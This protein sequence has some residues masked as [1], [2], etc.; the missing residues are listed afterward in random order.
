[1]D[2][3]TDDVKLLH[4]LLLLCVKIGTLVA[5]SSMLSSGLDFMFHTTKSTVICRLRAPPLIMAPCT[6]SRSPMVCYHKL[7]AKSLLESCE[8]QLFPQI[9][10][11]CKLRGWPLM[12]SV[13][14]LQRKS[15]NEF[16]F[17]A[18][19]PFENY[20]SWRR[21]SDIFF[22]WCPPAPPPPDH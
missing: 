9:I 3:M 16:T 7:M 20:F 21:A 11:F 5:P 4:P 13:V 15:K 8:H 18:E 10:T 2:R 6:V 19:M 1:M 17:S 22:S 12:I 14:G